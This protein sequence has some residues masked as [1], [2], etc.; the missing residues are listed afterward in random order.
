MWLQHQVVRLY[1]ITYRTSALVL[2]RSCSHQTFQKKL[3][4]GADTISCYI[5]GFCFVLCFCNC[6]AVEGSLAI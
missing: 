6:A 4:A 2:E 3:A 5:D 1:Q